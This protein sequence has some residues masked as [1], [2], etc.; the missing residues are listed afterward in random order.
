MDLREGP[1]TIGAAFSYV[2]ERI[3]RD[4]DLFPAPRVEL[5][6]YVLASAR[7]AYRISP[8]LEAFARVENGLDEDYQDV[9]GYATPGRSVHAGI[10][11]SL[12][13]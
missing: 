13:D 11:L 6:A 10:R 4:F 8:A 7:L 9:V 2:G 1:F 5:D 3:D 12:G